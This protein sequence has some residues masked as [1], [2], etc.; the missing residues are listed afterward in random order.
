[1]IMK[2]DELVKNAESDYF[3]EQQTLDRE[4]DLLMGLRDARQE[5]NGEMSSS[6]CAD[7]KDELVDY[8][9]QVILACKRVKSIYGV[10]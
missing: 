10:K 4:M 5:V 2:V 9:T 3:K 7:N 1:M 6:V 8:C